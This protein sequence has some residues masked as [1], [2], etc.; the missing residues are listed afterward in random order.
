MKQLI[1][2]VGSICSQ[3]GDCFPSG[4]QS[5]DPVPRCI[6][7]LDSDIDVYDGNVHQY[8]IYPDDNVELNP[9]V[10]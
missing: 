10:L 5:G 3:D 7:D 4:W 1:F 6:S 9:G 8:E 2:E